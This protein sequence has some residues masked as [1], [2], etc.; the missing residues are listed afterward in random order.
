MPSKIASPAGKISADVSAFV[1]PERLPVVDDERQP[2]MFP[3]H[4]PGRE[5]LLELVR[6]QQEALRIQVAV[7]HEL[8]ENA[9]RL[10][11]GTLTVEPSPA[12]GATERDGY[13]PTDTRHKTWRVQFVLDLQRIERIVRRDKQME[14]ND[15]FTKEMLFAAG[16]PTRRTTTNIMKGYGL[17]AEQW[18]PST[19]DPN[20]ARV[21]HSPHKKRPNRQI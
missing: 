4:D 10:N 18:P 2:P 1:L 6:L 8:L 7:S 21:W 20:E 3:S 17:R 5:L 11:D 9:R 16:G 12:P 14:P 15:E 13:G 19:W